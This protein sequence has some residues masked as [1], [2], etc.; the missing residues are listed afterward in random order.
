MTP[1]LEQLQDRYSA[2]AAEYH[3]VVNESMTEDGIDAEAQEKLTGLSVKL[4][5]LEDGVKAKQREAE[6]DVENMFAGQ[7]AVRGIS[8]DEQTAE[9]YGNMDAFH[10]FMKSKVSNRALRTE[11]AEIMNVDPQSLKPLPAKDRMET[12]SDGQIVNIGIDTDARG[13]YSVPDMVDSMLTSRTKHYSVMRRFCDVQTSMTGRKLSFVTED[14]T[15][16]VGEIVKP[17]NVQ[18]AADRGKVGEQGR[19]FGAVELEYNIFSSKRVSVDREYIMDTATP[20]VI[21][22]M[23]DTLGQRIGRAEEK[24]FAFGDDATNGV[25]LCDNAG[26][27]DT[28]TDGVVTYTFDPGNT[29]VPNRAVPAN[30]K[31]ITIEQWGKLLLTG[32]DE[33]YWDEAML[34]VNAGTLA[35]MWFTKDTNG[36]P[37]YMPSLTAGEPGTFLG[38]RVTTQPQFL[39]PLG[40]STNV[41][42][43]FV[44]R[45]FKIRDVTGFEMKFIDSDTTNVESYMQSYYG[46][47]R[48]GFAL[49]TAGEGFRLVST[50]AA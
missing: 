27:Q 39:D 28:G 38:R 18:S 33:T 24:A 42:A 29:G 30:D 15:G 31:S 3:K 43:Y 44:P 25:L 22:D 32:L 9:A 8:V 4:Q 19:L 11:A 10:D 50:P 45:M 2:T 48:T 5:S 20:S 21:G 35:A 26:W 6:V 16:N 36:R 46:F 23:A 49:V 1:T 7:A 12:R 34:M 17:G 41:A 14:D 13:G 47:L 37:A 40:A